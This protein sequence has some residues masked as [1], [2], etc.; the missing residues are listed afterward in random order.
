VTVSD[1]SL[2]PL[3][4]DLEAGSGLAF[5]PR[6]PGQ[7]PS[8]TWSA[9]GGSITAQGVFTAPAMDGRVEIRCS[10]GGRTAL[11]FVTV[12]R[13]KGLVVRPTVDIKAAGTYSLKVTLVSASGR[14]T[15]ASVRFSAEPGVTSP[16]VWFGAGAL[17]S[18]LGED[19]S[20]DV[21]EGV[22]LREEKDGQSV[23]AVAAN[24]GKTVPVTL[25]NLNTED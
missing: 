16:E 10:S 8:T 9:S 25:A 11:A 4:A 21:A 22:L 5:K 18:D 20:Y 7:S 6:G 19:G 17:A 13:P 2:E 1:L 24:L 12:H 15:Q 3:Q 23:M 14:S